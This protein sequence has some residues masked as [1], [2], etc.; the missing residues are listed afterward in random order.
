M[1]K[2]NH[3]TEPHTNGRFRWGWALAA[4]ALFIL[5][6]TMLLPRPKNLQ[7]GGD[8]PPKASASDSD[9]WTATSTLRTDRSSLRNRNSQP[10]VSAEEVVTNKV[11]Q[12]VRNRR[13]VLRRWAEHLKIKVPPLYEQFFDVAE[14]GNWDETHKAFESLL[15]GR[16]QGAWNEDMATLWPVILETDGVADV[17]HEWPAQ[18]LLD[19][20]QMMLS[21]L[22][23][24]MIYVGGT[25]PGRFIPT[26]FNETSEG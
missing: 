21:S 4:G 16:K 3:D 22:R 2:F 15:A 8:P 23:P 11:N 9:R 19:Y 6:I 18:Q 20:G 17:A 5:L 24:E 13:E 12:F 10:T 14:T 25:D 1:Q 26:L 7:D